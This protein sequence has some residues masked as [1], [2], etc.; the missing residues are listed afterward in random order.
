MIVCSFIITKSL[1]SVKNKGEKGYLM[2]MGRFRD[3]LT[4]LIFF[5]DPNS[6]PNIFVKNKVNATKHLFFGKIFL[7]TGVQNHAQMEF[8]RAIKQGLKSD[9]VELVDLAMLDYIKIGVRTG[10]GSYLKQYI[11]NY[12]LIQEWSINLKQSEY[13]YVEGYLVTSDVSRDAVLQARKVAAENGVKMAYTFSDPSMV[14]YFKEGVEEVLGDGVD[15]LFC[16]EEEAR[17]YSG[18]D[19]VDAA[20]DALIQKTQKLV[21]TMGSEGALVVNADGSRIQVPTASVEAI[22]TNGAGDMFAGAFL[23]GMTQGMSD[24]KAA[25]LANRAAGS[26][27]TVFGARLEKDVQQ[28]ILQDVLAG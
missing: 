3:Q 22:D 27:V 8:Q 2:A 11:K 12:E 23:Y 6:Y 18:A 16:N 1:K 7:L 10:N 15:I 28:S 20:I 4:N 9:F 26:M 13:L 25:T 17:I 14:T 5:L 19:S 24:E 21:V